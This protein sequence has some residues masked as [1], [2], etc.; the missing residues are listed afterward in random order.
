MLLAFPSGLT[1]TGN[2]KSSMKSSKLFALSFA[3]RRDSLKARTMLI[4]Q[5]M[6]SVYKS[7]P[8]GC[9]AKRGRAR[10][11]SSTRYRVFLIRQLRM[12][13]ESKGA[14]GYPAERKFRLAEL[15]R[16]REKRNSGRLFSSRVVSRDATATFKGCAG[17][18]ARERTRGSGNTSVI[19]RPSVC[20]RRRRL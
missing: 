10:A 12:G 4:S 20:F 17:T 7:T 3:S 5:R 2:E 8:R 18:R 15:E 16:D 6:S 19:T 14:E 11:M 1:Y 9:L 13:S